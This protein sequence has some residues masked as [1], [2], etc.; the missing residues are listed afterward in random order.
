MTCAAHTM[1]ITHDEFDI[2]KKSTRTHSFGC[3]EDQGVWRIS[4][5]ESFERVRRRFS[6]ELGI[7]TLSQAISELCCD[8]PDECGDDCDDSSVSSCS[9]IELCD[10]KD[11]ASAPL[12]RSSSMTN[13]KHASIGSMPSLQSF[14]HE[15]FTSGIFSESSDDNISNESKCDEVMK[16][17]VVDRAKAIQKSTSDDT[18]NELQPKERVNSRSKK[19]RDLRWGSQNSNDS[20]PS[21]QKHDR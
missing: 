12:K 11:S 1:I 6:K 15:S 16:V 8:S 18:D 17:L 19:K 5:G 13:T 2:P 21:Y 10:L 4:S 20:M 3:N 14:C 9:F 7:A